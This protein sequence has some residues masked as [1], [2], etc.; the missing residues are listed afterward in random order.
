MLGFCLYISIRIMHLTASLWKDNK[1]MRVNKDVKIN[2]KT[3]SEKKIDK[4]LRF[5]I[6]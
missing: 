3:T 5:G 4:S 6:E 1:A 2:I